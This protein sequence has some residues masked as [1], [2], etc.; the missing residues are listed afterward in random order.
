MTTSPRQQNAYVAVDGFGGMQKHC[1]RASGT[2]RGGNL[3]RNDAALAHAGDHHA[4]VLF[5]AA[6]H[7]VNGARERREHWPL[8]ACGQGFERRG[9]GANQSGG[10][11]I[12]SVWL[13]HRL[14]MVTAWGGSDASE[15]AAPASFVQ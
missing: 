13:V 12:V 10:F 14:L 7:Q 6:K 2:E 9:F 4:A 15:S 5:T 1:R 11:K 8:K 3:L